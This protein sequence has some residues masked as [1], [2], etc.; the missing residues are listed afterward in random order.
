MSKWG[1]G[2]SSIGFLQEF[3]E[4]AE[5][6]AHRVTIHISKGVQGPMHMGMG[7]TD[8]IHFLIYRDKFISP[9]DLRLCR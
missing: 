8:Q 1:S 2:T 3:V 5:Y 4:N 7:E 9:R 6:Q